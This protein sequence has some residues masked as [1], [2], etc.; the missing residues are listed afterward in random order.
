MTFPSPAANRRLAACMVLFLFFALAMAQ[1][2]DKQAAQVMGPA[3]DPAYMDLSVKPGDDFHAY[4]CGTW[5]K[6]TA[7]PP[8]RGEVS[9]G[10]PVFDRQ[11]RKLADLIEEAGK[12]GTTPTE[13]SRRVFDLYHSFMNEAAIEARGTKPLAAPLKAIADIRNRKQLARALGET[14]RAD[15]DALNVT[16]FHSPNLFGLWVALGFEDTSHYTAYLMQGGLALP[17]REYYLSQSDAMKETRLKY[18]A[19][20]ATMMKLAGFDDVDSRVDRILTLEHAIAEKHATL[21]ED[22]DVKKA[23]NPWKASEFAS[24]APGLDW[25]EYFSAAGLSKQGEFIVWQPSAVIAESALVAGASLESWKDW[26]AYHL[27]NECAPYLPKAFAEE[28]FALYGKT[29][30]GANE[31]FP[32]WRRGLR[33]VNAELGDDLGQI[34]VKRYFAPEV[35]AQVQ[36]LVTN[37]LV[38]YRK[39]IQAV[40][41]MTPSTKAE[42]LRKLDTLYVG[43]GY[44]ESWRDYVG[45]EVKPDDV[46]GNV[47][48]GELWEYQHQRAR[49]GRPVD[50]KEWVM[51][52]QTNNAVNLPLN[53]SLNF[54]AAGLQPPVFDPKA[55]AAANYGSLGATIGHEISH[56]FDNEGSAFDAEGRLRNWWTPEDFAHFDAET[57]KLVAQYDA[58]KPFPDL[59][60]NGKQ[61]L[62]ENLADVAGLSA[63]YDAYAASLQGQAAAAQGRFTGDQEFFLAYAQ[64][65]AD[66]MRDAALREEV[67]T[68]THSP[69]QYRALA[70][71]NLNKW[72]EAFDVK[73]GDKLYL[74]PG[75]RVLIW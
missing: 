67:L 69:A 26:L 46:V 6:N 2:T 33:L 41:W 50:K 20:I 22:N 65:W 42:A 60:L 7:I 32:R 73:P 39:R 53:N 30:F 21:A 64:S 12:K 55:P 24:K 62:A 15:E 51:T 9:P 49:L 5:E 66:K 25:V 13:H 63:A 37:L 36:E 10:T 11:D 61:T 29:L 71:R 23:N 14:L 52:L 75:D 43:V 8:D 17:D 19:H 47:L 28:D 35:K 31:Q 56:A 57:V 38:V 74:E 3:V 44:A 59:S 16:N 27:I 58:Y 4:C 34:Y 68:D 40:R 54:P 18:R 70:V 45:F 72:Y 1:Q 48:R